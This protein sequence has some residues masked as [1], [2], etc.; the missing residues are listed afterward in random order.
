M[1][2]RSIFIIVMAAG[3]PA[4]CSHPNG[5][6]SETS[7]AGKTVL[8][9]A[10][11]KDAQTRV[12]FRQH[13]KPVLETKCVMCHNRKTLPGRMSLENKKLAMARGATGIPIVPGHPEQS[14]L[15]TNI[16]SAHA[17]VNVMPPVGERITKDELAV[18]TKWIKDGA[19]W[20]EGRAGRL[21]PDWKPGE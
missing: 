11:L 21:D 20:P 9:A 13:V 16:K 15:L 18:L 12:D 4:A 2:T 10:A 19:Q 3:L 5:N 7:P 14:L 1:N 6:G 17:H 8:S